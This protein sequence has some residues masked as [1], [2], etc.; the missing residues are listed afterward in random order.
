MSPWKAL[1]GLAAAS[2]A[3]HALASG[4][5]CGIPVDSMCCTSSQ[6][7]DSTCVC[8]LQGPSCTC[9]TATGGTQTGT[10]IDCQL[11]KWTYSGVTFQIVPGADA[12]CFK[13]YNCLSGVPESG[14]STHCGGEGGCD[15]EPSCGWA[16][17][18]TVS[19]PTVAHAGACPN[20]P[21]PG[22]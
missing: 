6:P 2:V 9:S 1:L 14:Y 3:S 15:S 10:I 4:V 5:P 19:S 21:A 11:G 20:P 12:V 16:I 22:G 17:V 13:L 7:P 18:S 8:R